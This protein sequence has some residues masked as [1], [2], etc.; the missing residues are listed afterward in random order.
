M[1]KESAFPLVR[2]GYDPSA[3]DLRLSSDAEKIAA[4]ENELKI[5]RDSLR[6]AQD[7]L[8][9]L[10]SR[11]G[12]IDE[13]LLSAG[14]MAEHILG[15]ARKQADEII[16]KS[17]EEDEARMLKLRQDREA[18]EATVKRV[19]Y[20]LRSQLAVVDRAKEELAIP[21]NGTEQE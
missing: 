18:L 21:N 7:K 17:R 20:I 12:L 4:Q 15:D 8:R 2:K 11:Q 14:V 16:A 3:V 5:L 13:T 1:K 9:E 10:E 19:E 6:I